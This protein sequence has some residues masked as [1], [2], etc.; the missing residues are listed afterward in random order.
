M[1]KFG[2]R[3]KLNRICKIRPGC[4]FF[5]DLGVLCLSAF[6]V[7]KDFC[8]FSLATLHQISN[9]GDF[10]LIFFCFHQCFAMKKEIKSCMNA[11]KKSITLQK[12][13]DPFFFKWEKSPG[14]VLFIFFITEHLL[15]IGSC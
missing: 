9:L 12:Y 5:Y 10:P 2:L 4:L 1:Y 8:F 13:D 3:Y 14:E 11:Y 6:M 15:L 7:K